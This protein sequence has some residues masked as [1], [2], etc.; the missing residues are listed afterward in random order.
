MSETRRGHTVADWQPIETAPVCTRLLVYWPEWSDFPLVA[1]KDSSG[2]WRLL[3]NDIGGQKSW[4][5][6]QCWA[7]LPPP[8]STE[9]Q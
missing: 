8:P 5:P 3:G 6:P 7:Y 9:G 4:T 1:V 2:G